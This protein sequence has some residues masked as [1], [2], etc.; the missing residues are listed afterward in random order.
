MP[1]IHILPDHLVNQIA[2]GEVVERPSSVVKELIENALDAGSRSVAIALTAGG[3]QAIAIADDGQGMGRDDALLA[4]DRHAT[5][6]IAS[7]EDL[8]QISTLGFRGEALAAVA[9]V[10]KVELRT[11]ERP[12]EG[13]RIKV[14]GGRILA[15]EPVAHP[16][17]TAI[18]VRSLFWNV[19]ARRQFLK[20][21]EVE[22]RRAVEVIEGYALAYPEI[23]F[24][25]DHGGRELLVAP[26]LEAAPTAHRTRIAALFGDE[27]ARHLV[28][29]DSGESE[30]AW[31]SGFLGPREGNRARR[32]FVFVNRRLVRDR[33][34]LATFYR[35][36]REEWKSEEFPSL[37]LF[38][39]L[40]AAEVDVNVH[41]QKAEVR[42][43][44]P[45]L[46][47]RLEGRLRAALAQVPREV[48]APV[49]PPQGRPASL[50]ASDGLGAKE[51]DAAPEG[52]E[53]REPAVPMP[54]GWKIAEAAY[55]PAQRSPVPLSGRDGE[56]RPHRFLGQYKASLLLLEGPDGLYLIDQH[57]A[58]E[59]VLYER[60]R[61]E[62]AVES[63]PSQTLV[64]PKLLE[65]GASERL[66]LLELAPELARSGF[67][68]SELS[69]G[70]VGISAIPA[71]LKASQALALLEALAADRGEGESGV[72]ARLLD[73]LAAALACRA[74]VKM[75]RPLSAVAAER[76]AAELFRCEQPY[77]CPHG[78]PI[79][80]TL[81]DAELERRF[82]RR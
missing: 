20:G 54:S 25:L 33:A 60:L 3:K 72:G 56:V 55:A 78:R 32:S 2:A 21:P 77:A 68:L 23:R 19:P 47:G 66:R 35:A 67:A 61:R 44:D 31:L 69:E 29:I 28:A 16:T 62:L 79:V 18:E 26:A 42:F 51:G 39:D 49:R 76:L 50:F 64:E 75:H 10:S 82:G 65:L 53:I 63:P 58:H 11:A 46:L 24:T 30:R 48:A 59:R 80:M 43:R 71:A 34:I 57:V 22:L 40:P 74:A 36:V 4:F 15:V 38:F 52:E 70:T 5:S 73:H 41:P 17:G 1:R 9:A 7:F 14:E 8:A 13:Y 45:E 12:G 27:L 37:F 81:T 6:K